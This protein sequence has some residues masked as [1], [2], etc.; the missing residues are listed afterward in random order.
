MIRRCYLP[1][2]TTEQTPK[3][4]APSRRGNSGDN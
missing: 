2:Q 4:R 3:C 1:A